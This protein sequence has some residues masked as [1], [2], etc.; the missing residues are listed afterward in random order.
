MF[1]DIINGMHSIPFNERDKD[2]LEELRK[3]SQHFL[4]IKNQ[5]F[6]RYF[7]QNTSLTHR[8]LVIIGQ[9]GIGKTT[10]LIQYLLSQVNNDRF[11]PDILYV[12]CDHFIMGK[13]SLYEVAED[14]N[15]LGGKINCI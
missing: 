8:L 6:K 4:E 10:T 15:A 13:T 12:Q 3:L 14:F 9:R 7:I 11:S 1:Y 5:Q 2:M